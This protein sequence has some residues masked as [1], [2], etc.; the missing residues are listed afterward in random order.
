MRSYSLL[1]PAS[2]ALSERLPKY[3]MVPNPAFKPPTRLTSV[4][5]K[6][7]GFVWID[8][9]AGELARIEGEVTEALPSAC[10]SGKSTRA[11]ISCT[12]AANFCPGCGCPAFRSTISTVANCFPG[13]LYK[14]ALSIQN[15]RYIGSPK[16]ALATIRQ[17][18]GHAE[19]DKP[20]P[21]SAD[22]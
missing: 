12:S 7:R 15:Y 2:R 22:P 6:V 11:D 9:A 8:E 5:P 3:R 19:L 16:E 17:A 10:F 18:L 21:D 1:S 13:S 14:S 4:F 20:G